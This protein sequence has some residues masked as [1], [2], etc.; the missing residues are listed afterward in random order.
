MDTAGAF[1]DGGPR[2]D[3][4]AMSSERERL[5]ARA[6]G[7]LLRVLPLLESPLGTAIDVTSGG[8][9]V[10]EALAH[11]LR[12]ADHGAD[13]ETLVSARQAALAAQTQL[14]DGDSEED[15]LE[16]VR[17]LLGEAAVALEE[18]DR[19]PS[20]S[21][22][23]ARH[24][25]RASGPLPV[26]HAVARVEAL[27]PSLRLAPS[28]T[29]VE[30]ASYEPLP[31]PT[32]LEE[33]E[34]HGEKLRAHIRAH[35]DDVMAKPDPVGVPPDVP[36]IEGT[37]RFVARWT[38]ECFDEV[39]MLGSQRRPLPG[40]DWRNVRDLEDR[41]V[42]NVDAFASLVAGKKGHGDLA[43]V[44][45]LVL[46]APAPDPW[47]LFGAGML[48]GGLAG[49]DTLAMIDRLAC[50]SARDDEA[51]PALAAALRVCPHPARSTVVIEGSSS[52]AGVE[53]CFETAASRARSGHVS[54]SRT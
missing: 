26:L 43:R 25:L 49:R 8:A 48:L 31:P 18:A 17:A 41:L 53:A 45:E 2:I 54:S 3:K 51:L 33:L 24:P 11:V 5:I 37:V 50:A 47:R 40:E 14:D 6:Q 35:L 10:T 29:S 12:S 7:R 15:V 52:P 22:E 4:V 28:V 38:R 36:M 30:P 23:Q 20:A 9:L 32:T 16:Q 27:V 42:W 21:P 39:A 46:D 19:L 1:A 13:G 34:S 44:E